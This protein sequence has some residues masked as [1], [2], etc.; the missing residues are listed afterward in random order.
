MAI[1]VIDLFDELLLVVA[2]LWFPIL[3]DRH[4]PR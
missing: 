2:E 1:C 3:A 4:G